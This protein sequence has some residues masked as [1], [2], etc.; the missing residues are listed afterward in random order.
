MY[1][2]IQIIILILTTIIQVFYN[3]IFWVVV[4]IIYLQYKKIENMEKEILGTNKETTLKRVF[5]STLTGIVGGLIGSIIIIGLGI[6]IEA[7]DFKYIFIV[8]ILLMLIHPRFLCFSYGGGIV[9][10][11]SLLFGYP[12]INVSSIMA[13]V[14]ILH[15]VESF[16]ILNDGEKSKI[17]IFVKKDNRIVGGFSMI[18]FWPIPFIVLIVSMGIGGKEGVSMPEWWPL[19][20]AE[21]Y[22]MLEDVSYY[23]VGVMAALGYGDMALTEYPEKKIKESARNL[24]LF[25]IVLLILAVISSYI[26]VFKYVAAVFSPIVHELLIQHGKKKE[27]KGKP[28]F[29]PPVRGIKILDIMPNSIA[30]KIGL[31]SGDIIFSINGYT[32]D[33]MG[34][35]RKVLAHIPTYIWIDYYNRKGHIKT[36]DYSDYRNGIR[37]LGILVVPDE[38]SNT[39]L[40]KEAESL[41]VRLLRKIKNKMKRK[42]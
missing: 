3:P 42:F 12:D 40:V 19:F 32:I 16:L 41:G 33:T 5:S 15:L 39:I 21:G 2:L 28:I 13:I 18:R 26:Y 38:Y 9:S 20:R 34:Q 31:K 37:N 8:A 36:K 1:K 17:P 14:G 4:G 10:I 35:V 11:F 7:N 29:V 6:S 25:S 22:N 27:R 30:E 23:M 24:F